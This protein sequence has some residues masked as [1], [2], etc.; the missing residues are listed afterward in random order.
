MTLDF[1]PVLNYLWVA[2]NEHHVAQIKNLLYSIFY[3][4]TFSWNVSFISIEMHLFIPI[5]TLIYKTQSGS[6]A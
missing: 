5:T 4:K 6:D 3:D 2:I 1:Y